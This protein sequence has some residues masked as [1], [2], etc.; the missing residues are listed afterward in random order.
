MPRFGHNDSPRVTAALSGRQLGG[1]WA[2]YTP[3]THGGNWPLLPGY[4][5]FFGRRLLWRLHKEIVVSILYRP[6]KTAMITCLTEI[7]LIH[8]CVC[9]CDCA[10]IWRETGWISLSEGLIFLHKPTKRRPTR[11]C[12]VLHSDCDFMSYTLT[13][14]EAE[15]LLNTPTEK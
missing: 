7:W 1:D 12:I 8:L 14:T 9:M 10:R 4:P 5:N 11:K 2:C 15:P 3:K 6:H 13:T